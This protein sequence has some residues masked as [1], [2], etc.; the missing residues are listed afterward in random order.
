M[1]GKWEK[2]EKNPILV[3]NADW[4]CPGHGS[5][6]KYNNK[7]YYLYHAYSQTSS[8]YVGRQDV[9]EELYWGDNGWPYFK[10]EAKYDRLNTS[11]NFIDNFKKK[12][13]EPIWQWRVTQ[14]INYT[15]G[16]NG[17]LLEAS[18]EN[19]EL[20]SLLVQPI[21]ALDFVLTATINKKTTTSNA[22]ISII[23]AANNGF[24]APLA[25]IG[26]SVTKGG[27]ETWKTVDGKTTVFNHM[28]VELPDEVCI[29]IIVSKGYLLD[30]EYLEEGEW[31][32]FSDNVD[33]SPYVPWG[34]GFRI[35]LCAKGSLGTFANFKRIEFIH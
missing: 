25:G 15:T 26:I 13:L 35:G 18:T 10:N 2:Y 14:K 21:K 17:L 19:K 12:T 24:G 27:V 16:K 1:L 34:M 5:I 29:R 30:F 7:E 9:L 28:E 32:L 31:K 33:V 23:G 22:G 3:D 6:V 11:L 8:V 20:G 4:R